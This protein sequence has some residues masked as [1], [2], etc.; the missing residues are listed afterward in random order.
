MA[1]DVN[2]FIGVQNSR[3]YGECGLLVLRWKINDARET[4]GRNRGS[5]AISRFRPKS[6]RMQVAAAHVFLTN[7][8]PESTALTLWTRKER[9]WA[10]RTFRTLGSAASDAETRRAVPPG[11]SP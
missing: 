4:C 7:E 2:D 1:S 10:A 8:F 11:R 6:R 3:R 5:Y 9:V